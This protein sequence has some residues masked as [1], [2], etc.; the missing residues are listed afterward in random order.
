MF[1]CLMEEIPLSKTHLKTSRVCF[2]SSKCS[3]YKVIS[4]ESIS[5]FCSSSIA[6]KYDAEKFSSVIDQTKYSQH[7]GSKVNSNIRLIKV[8]V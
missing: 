3:L 1:W 8:I 5:G 6:A 4:Y 7:A 2:I